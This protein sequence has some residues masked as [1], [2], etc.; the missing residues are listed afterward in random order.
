MARAC[1]AAGFEPD[2]AFVTTDP[3]ASA[4]LCAEGLAVCLSPRTVA[5]SLPGVR[6]LAVRGPAPRRA[7]FALTPAVG[8]RHDARAFVDALRA[9]WPRP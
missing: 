9:T 3:L 4:G 1:R 8:A 7:V 6:R 2:I 5:A